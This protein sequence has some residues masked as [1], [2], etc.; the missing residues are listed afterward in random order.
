ML[1]KGLRGA[2]KLL[3][4]G[5]KAAY[6][7]LHPTGVAW[8]ESHVCDAVSGPRK[9]ATVMKHIQGRRAACLPSAREREFKVHV[10]TMCYTSHSVLI[11]IGGKNKK[12][13]VNLKIKMCCCLKEKVNKYTICYK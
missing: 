6:E 2:Y 12:M 4:K 7:M 1:E 8:R 13:A 3:E 11:R 9:K 10:P 5:P